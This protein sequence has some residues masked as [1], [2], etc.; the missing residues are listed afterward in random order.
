MPD[1]VDEEPVALRH[2]RVPVAPVER[3]FV[4][5][6]VVVDGGMLTAADE[7]TIAAEVAA[8]SRELAGRL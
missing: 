5:G 6:R 2:H 7:H 8:A 4:N 3:L 1:E